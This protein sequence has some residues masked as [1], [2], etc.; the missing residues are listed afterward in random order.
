[1][2]DEKLTKEIQKA[3]LNEKEALVYSC[4]LNLGGA[5]P[6]TI[7]REANINRSTTYKILTELSIKG[8][9]NEIERR[10][11][12]FYQI[13]KPENLVRLS[14]TRQN[15]LES[16][17]E[18]AQRLLPELKYLLSMTASKPK[19]LFYEGADEIHNIYDD[20]ISQPKK[21]EMLALANGHQLEKFLPSAYYKKYREAKETLDIRCRGIFPDTPENRSFNDRTYIGL[22]PKILP[23]IKYLDKKHFP[24]EVEITMYGDSKVSFAK[25]S[26]SNVVGVIIDDAVIHNSMK[27]MFELAWT[28]SLVKN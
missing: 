18:T 16:E 1:M 10:N 25:L 4:L 7:A 2:L 26:S 12:L 28:S 23:K 8:L 27:M 5:F 24:Y 20:H 11:K 22:N 13:D 17:L 21:Y 19:V 15:N 9:V 3:G 14:K 6:S